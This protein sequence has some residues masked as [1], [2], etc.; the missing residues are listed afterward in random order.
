MHNFTNYLYDRVLEYAWCQA[1][2]GCLKDMCWVNDGALHSFKILVEQ[3]SQRYFR[4]VSSV[5]TRT[6]CFLAGRN[7]LGH[8]GIIMNIP[9]Y[10]FLLEMK[11][12]ML[13]FFCF[14]S[15][16]PLFLLTESL[17]VSEELQVKWFCSWRESALIM[18][19]WKEPLGSQCFSAVPTSKATLWFIP[20][21]G[22]SCNALVPQRS[23]ATLGL[24]T[25]PSLVNFC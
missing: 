3:K 19:M 7:A 18:Y 14:F 15:L 8:S 16:L 6:R 11:T 21:G 1:H 24:S 23:S 12:E 22:I 9:I 13:G 17:A 4:E 10:N 25:L 5:S 20:Q 2:D